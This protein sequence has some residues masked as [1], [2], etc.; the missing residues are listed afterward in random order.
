M[1][2]WRIIF[3]I[4]QRQSII[5]GDYEPR[6]DECD[7]TGIGIPGLSSLD[8]EQNEDVD[9]EGDQNNESSP[10]DLND[11]MEKMTIEEDDS[12]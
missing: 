5:V 3:F 6:D 12:Q 4:C 10:I 7:L 1:C 8:E 2:N 11:C 9:I